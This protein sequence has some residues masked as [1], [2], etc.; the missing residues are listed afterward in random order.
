MFPIVSC[1]P[2]SGRAFRPAGRPFGFTL[3]ELLA[4]VAIVAVLAALLMPALTAAKSR[5]RRTAC[6]NNLKQLGLAAQLYS[7]DNDSRLVQNQPEVVGATNNW[8]EGNMRIAENAVNA[9]Y[10][11]EG[12]LFPYASQPALFHCPADAS[13]T[14]N[15]LR[16]RSY[17]M[18]GWMGSRYYEQE[19]GSRGY[20]TFVREAE[21]VAAGPAGLWL[22]LDEHEQ[23]ID[24]GWFPVT[25]DDSHP[26]GSFPATR[27]EG[28]YGLDFA[29]G[30]AEL[31]KLRDP[32]SSRLGTAAYQVS[33]GNGDWIR[34]KQITTVK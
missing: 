12:R 7:A 31:L 14:N 9:A 6:S 32:E 22:V 4:V 33:P 21:L 27:H 17:S 5:S 15:L 25:M 24:D 8:V 30:H 34:L 1:R 10:L 16:V 29:D 20:R 2:L 26:F 3:V 18:N 23:S 13:F 28:G 11:R 19:Q